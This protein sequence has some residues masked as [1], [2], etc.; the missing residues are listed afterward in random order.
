MFYYCEPRLNDGLIM[1]NWTWI[2]HKNQKTSKELS[3]GG[4]GNNASN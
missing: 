2:L 4:I 3:L 1:I